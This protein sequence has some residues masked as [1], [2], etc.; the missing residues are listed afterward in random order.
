ME[1]LDALQHAMLLS[2]QCSRV[3]YGIADRALWGTRFSVPVRAARLLEN[4]HIQ[5]ISGPIMSGAIDQM[6]V[7]ERH[8]Q[9]YQRLDIIEPGSVREM[10]MPNIQYK[11]HGRGDAWI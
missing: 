6:I 9:V 7:D 10:N 1:A 5:N 3:Q 8:G 4:R 11:S 2:G